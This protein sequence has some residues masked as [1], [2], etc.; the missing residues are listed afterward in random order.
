MDYEFQVSIANKTYT[1]FLQPGF[2]RM[3]MF[4]SNLHKHNYAELHLFLDGEVCINVNKS[5]HI[6]KSGDFCLIP[7]QSYHCFDAVS[8]K[9][10]HTAFQIAL[11]CTNFQTGKI[12][13]QAAAEFIQSIHDRNYTKISAYIILLC[14][15]FTNDSTPAPVVSKDYAFIISEFFSTRYT[16]NIHL[17]AL[18]N[19]LHLS[20]KQ[21]ARLVKKYTG[22][23]FNEAITA[24]RMKTADY[25]LATSKMT[26]AEIAVY[27]GYHSY[28]GFW[29]AYQKHQQK[30]KTST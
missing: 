12:S 28:S 23:T 30:Q 3:N 22:Y 10:I 15:Q 16:E 20:E 6:L 17:E 14:A 1:V 27:V 2:F 13:P 21:T 18:S 4:S 29:K 7:P 19:I 25:L 26:M 8:Q 11:P 9:T 5:K 24:H